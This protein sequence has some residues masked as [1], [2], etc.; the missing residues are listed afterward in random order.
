MVLC[1]NLE[2]WD[3][4]GGGREIQ[5]RGNICKTVADLWQCM[6][7]IGIPSPPLDLFVVMLSKAHLIS[8][9]RMS[10]SS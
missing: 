1:D 8:H 10:G 5:E 2:G 9:S 4:V 6:A 7:A 3:G